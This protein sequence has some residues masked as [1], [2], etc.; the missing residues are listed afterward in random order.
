MEK[1]KKIQRTS[2]QQRAIKLVKDGFNLDINGFAGT[3]KS[4]LIKDISSELTK[5]NRKFV[6]LAPTGVAAVNIQG[7]TFHSYFSIRPSAVLTEES[8]IWVKKE[9]RQLWENVDTIIIDEKSMLRADIL[10]AAFWNMRKNGIYK[11]HQWIFVGDLGQLEPVITKNESQVYYNIYNS[12]YYYESIFFQQIDFKYVNLTKVHRQKDAEFIDALNKVRNGEKAHYFKQFVNLDKKDTEIYLCPT[13]QQVR[14]YNNEM[15][16]KI[17][18]PLIFI[19]GFPSEEATQNDFTV[20]FKLILKDTCKIMY[21]INDNNGYNGMIGHLEVR[22]NTYWFIKSNG[23]KF[24]LSYYKW[25]RIEYA[26]EKDVLI[27]KVKSYVTQ[28]PIKLA[29]SL[30]FHKA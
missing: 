13:N 24:L 1:L 11:K 22:N 6:L 10:D 17:D 20:D 3:G 25:E 5:L 16:T 4:F 18:K 14:E 26:W 23:Q 9:K 27:K 8:A 19:D 21:L 12:P 28:L 7:S 29:F 15:L 30:T 2:A